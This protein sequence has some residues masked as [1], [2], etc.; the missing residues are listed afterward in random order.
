MIIQMG[1]GYNSM[2]KWVASIGKV[3]YQWRS[4]IMCFWL[5]Y[6]IT[7]CAWYTLEIMM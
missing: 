3:Y 4:F 6:Y 5:K 7:Y 1:E 2:V